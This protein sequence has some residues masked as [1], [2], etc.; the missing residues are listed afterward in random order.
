MPCTC[1]YTRSELA[2]MVVISTSRLRTSI[3][4]TLGEG[5]SRLPVHV[6]VTHRY[7]TSRPERMLGGL[8]GRGVVTAA[9]YWKAAATVSFLRDALLVQA[10]RVG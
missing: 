5:I 4:L 10:E 3:P 9:H 1:A 7:G 6:C 8:G 2:T